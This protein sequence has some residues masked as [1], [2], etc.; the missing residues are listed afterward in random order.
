MPSPTRTARS[1]AVALAV[2][3]LTTGRAAH[4]DAADDARAAFDAGAAAEQRGAWA[5]AAAAYQRAYD[6]KPHPYALFNLGR[7]LEHDGAR[8]QAAM[9]YQR[10]LDESPAAADRA[11]V[12]RTIA[13]LRAT[14]GAL[15]ITSALAGAP[16]AAE[17]TID[18]T[19]RG[20][21]P[22]TVE[23]PGGPHRVELTLGSRRASR[24]VVTEFGEPLAL[25]I[26]VSARPGTLAVRANIEGAAVTIDGFLAGATP[27]RLELP[28]GPHVVDVSATG[29]VGSRQ[30]T[31][32]A[33]GGSAAL[34]FYLAPLPTAAPAIAPT[35]DA[36]TQTGV[37]GVHAL[38]TTT[39]TVGLL[40]SLGARRGGVTAGLT[41]G[42][43][44]GHGLYGAYADVALGRRRV[45]PLLGIMVGYVV[46]DVSGFALAPTAGLEVHDVLP[47][48]GVRVD[49]RLTASAIVELAGGAHVAFPFGAALVFARR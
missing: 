27:L 13:A 21:A 28:A 41:L 44:D 37:L 19:A 34:A 39:G 35:P 25:A 38:A 40:G 15:T 10:Y 17:V 12:E 32:L 6:L 47:P 16:V 5:E 2:L 11:R 26:D 48:L 24:D 42:G 43:W 14:P 30:S 4:A 29:R 36:T 23:L 46:A 18:G 49:L 22:L 3:L 1:A 33:P 31:T 9:A 45:A 7:A 8:R 20:A